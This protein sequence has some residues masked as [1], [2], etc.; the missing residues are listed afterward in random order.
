MNQKKQMEELFDIEGISFLLSV[1]KMFEDIE[2]F[3]KLLKNFDHMKLRDFLD[4]EFDFGLKIILDGFHSEFE[5]MNFLL[6]E[7]N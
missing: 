2:L 1:K 7:K 5:I 4:L 3:L 6:L